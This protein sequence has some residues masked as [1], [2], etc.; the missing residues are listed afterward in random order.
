MPWTDTR[1]GS[2]L[3]SRYC[4]SGSERVWK[5]RKGD[6]PRKVLRIIFAVLVAKT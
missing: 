3:P 1:R 4:S 6:S 5:E 2:E